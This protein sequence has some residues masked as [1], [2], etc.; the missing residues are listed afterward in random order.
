MVLG[1]ANLTEIILNI[2]ANQMVL[3]S[4]IVTTLA[5]SK[6]NRIVVGTESGLNV[7]ETNPTNQNSNFKNIIALNKN[8]GLKVSILSK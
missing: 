2:T 5:V 8:D 6:D 7:I 1:S 3:S 4:N